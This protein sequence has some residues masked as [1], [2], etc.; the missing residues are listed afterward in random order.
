MYKY[1]IE[2]IHESALLDTFWTDKK[3]TYPRPSFP[4]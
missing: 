4:D 1:F 2:I 3:S